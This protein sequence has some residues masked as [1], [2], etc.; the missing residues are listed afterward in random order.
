MRGERR[1]H[2]SA[3]WICLDHQ[4][5]KKD[6]KARQIWDHLDFSSKNNSFGEN[7]HSVRTFFDTFPKPSIILS[8]IMECVYMVTGLWTVLPVLT[9][10]QYW[11]PGISLI[12]M[13]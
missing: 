8:N 1:Q 11:L 12:S 13:S 9:M 3:F 10:L 4:G 6:K 7:D 2:T 5:N